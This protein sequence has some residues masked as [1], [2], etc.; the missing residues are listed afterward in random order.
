MQ[1]GV[2]PVLWMCTHSNYQHGLKPNPSNLESKKR[3]LK[4]MHAGLCVLG[5]EGSYD[6]VAAFAR[7]WKV[8][9]LDRGNAAR[10]GTANSKKG[11]CD[12]SIRFP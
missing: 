11:L 7:Q 9:Q 10:K 8:D 6:R 2:Q 3:S 12:H 1:T 5:F 4:Q